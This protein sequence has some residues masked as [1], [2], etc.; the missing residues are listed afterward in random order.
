ML[1]IAQQLGI[2]QVIGVT[3]HK[4][5]PMRGVCKL[6]L[7]MGPNIIEPCP[8]SLTPSASIAVML[9]IS[10]AIALTLMALKDFTKED[11]GRRHH[12][13]YLGSITRTPSDAQ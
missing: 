6:I 10:D 13:G 11:Y 3:S 12:S 5:S 8:L 1:Q 2:G 4:D 7:D 9:A